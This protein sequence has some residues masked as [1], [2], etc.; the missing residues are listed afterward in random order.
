MKVYSKEI[1]T[2]KKAKNLGLEILRML[3]CFWIVV[4]HSCHVK[5][6]K[7]DKIKNSQFHV[8]GFMIISFYF[9]Y[10]IL[11]KRNINKIKSRFE[12]LLIPYI[13]WP[14]LI[15]IV[16][17]L[18]LMFN[19]DSII[20]KKLGLY[21]LILQY[22]FG[23][24]INRLFWFQ[25][26][27]LFITLYFSIISI[28]FYNKFVIVLFISMIISYYLQYSGINFKYFL[29]FNDANYRNIGSIVEI[30]PL[31]ITG[32]IFGFFKII[33][34]CKHLRFNI[35][36]IS[37][38]IIYFL[39]QYDVINDIKGYRYPGIKV[40]IGG[41]FL[42]IPFSIMPVEKIKI[43]MFNNLINCITKHTGG[44]YYLHIIIIDYLKKK[45]LLI[46]NATFYGSIIIYLLTYFICFVG[47]KA[48]HKT[49]FIYLFN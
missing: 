4:C 1:K 11:I 46:Q 2:N 25:F 44:I 48:F 10:D 16:N 35:I 40:N 30:M 8:P 29:K 26:N 3:L 17:N 15:L 24:H 5:N 6:K 47:T 43:P 38:I 9:C 41:I 31:A 37:V 28:A 14:I 49:K 36:F 19:F 45:I 32:I 22:L 13:I 27:L 34:V 39:L 42:F 21:D 12:R 33:I 7:L 23:R 18:L 20:A